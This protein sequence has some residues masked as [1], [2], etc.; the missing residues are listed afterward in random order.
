MITR[1]GSYFKLGALAYFF[2]EQ[3][4][5]DLD[6]ASLWKV[7]FTELI[8]MSNIAVGGSMSAK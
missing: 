2:S 4:K 1:N 3:V 7:F 5:R 8:C 6:S